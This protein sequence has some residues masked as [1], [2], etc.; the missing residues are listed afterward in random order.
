MLPLPGDFLGRLRE[1]LLRRRAER[2]G[3]LAVQKG[4]LSRSSLEALWKA[5][6]L[7]ELEDAIAAKGGLSLEDRTPSG[8]D[9]PATPSGPRHLGHRYQILEFLGEGAVAEVYRGLDLELGRPVAVKMLRDSFLLND[10]A[11]RRFLR[12]AQTL[13][14]LDHPNILKV[15]DV[16]EDQGRLYLV[17]ELVEG[18]SLATLL[19]KGRD[20]GWALAALVQAARGLH[21]AH[22][23]GIVHRDLKPE[24][25]LATAA[26]GLKVADFGLAHLMDPAPGH[27]TRTGAILGTPLYMAPEQVRGKTEDIRPTT[28]VYAL[29]AILYRIAAGRPPHTAETVVDLFEKIVKADIVPIRKIRPGVSPQIEAIAQK[30]LEKDPGRRYPSAE[31]F[32]RE[33]ENHLE[34]RPITARSSSFGERLWRRA[35][36]ERGRLAALAVAFAALLLGGALWFRIESKDRAR[37]RALALL[38]SARPPLERASGALYRADAKFGPLHQGLAEARGRAEEAL[39]LTPELPV[40]HHRLG[41][42][43]ELQGGFEQAE[44]SWRRAL[45][46]DPSLA[47]TAYR[48]GRLLLWRAF[49]TTTPLWEDPRGERRARAERLAR[50][51]ADLL[52]RAESSGFGAES[53]LRRRAASA[54][55]LFLRDDRDPARKACEAGIRDFDGAEGVEEFHWLSSL[56]E[57]TPAARIEA[58]DRALALKPGNPLALYVRAD[59]KHRAGDPAAA[60]ADYDRALQSSPDFLEARLYRGACLYRLGKAR[61]AI[62]DFDFLIGRGALLAAA[63]NGRGYARIDLLGDAAGAQRDF[64]EALRLQ[65]EDYPLP[66]I[67]RGKARLRARD[68]AGA[69]ADFTKALAMVSWDPV[70]HQRMMARLLAG[71][72]AGALDD[73]A[74]LRPAERSRPS[75]EK[76]LERL[77]A[78][79]EESR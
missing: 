28:D 52:A 48:L 3:E 53:E 18:A 65:P 62:G 51:G 14:R 7:A 74:L 12:E 21:H 57:E 2:L 13:A 64:D 15:F 11:R 8:E 78:E 25:I 68:F 33:I 26:G 56:L 76:E 45:E 72:R 58:V 44:S 42:I 22:E 4:A 10:A 34:G 5:V 38:E 71:N 55:L 31:A 59:A 24:N 73:L 67:G 27:L 36:R 6:P 35:S 43:L 41:E 69:E 20:E 79:F 19:E 60:F 66:Y 9:P 77:R 1:D 46:L 17:L 63:L 40:A 75:L 50:E 32:A 70:R 23:K 61:E 54:T 29:G 49:L 16:G 47:A 37:T 39:R 30:A